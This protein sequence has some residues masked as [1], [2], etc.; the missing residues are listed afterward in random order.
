MRIAAAAASRDTRDPLLT[1]ILAAVEPALA[2][3]TPDLGLLFASSHF[4]DELALAAERIRQATGVR[5]LLGCTAE[6]VIGPDHEHEREPAL[7]LWLASLPGATVRPFHVTQAALEEAGDAASWR[8]LF[9]VEG[10]EQ[11]ALLVLGDPFT[12]NPATLLDGFNRHLPGCPLVGGMASGADGPGQSAL[13]LDGQVH[14]CGAVGV[15]L[16][17]AVRVDTVVSQ[18][19]RPVGQPYVITRAEGNLLYQLG[20]R[21][22]LAV[23]NQVFAEAP[24]TDQEL[25][26]S[27]G[28]YLGRAINEQQGQ[29]R[30]GDF[31]IRNLLG[32]ADEDSGALAVGDLLR[33]GITVQFHVRDAAT[34]A[35]DLRTLL[36]QAAPQPAGVLLFSCNGRGTR[37]FASRD[38]DLL[39]TRQALGPVPVA[40]FFCAGEL[41]PVGGRNFI[42]GHTASLA[43]FRPA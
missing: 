38:Q 10:V 36:G 35:E 40:G 33:V 4:E 23:L 24:A 27:Q 5:T 13:L 34:A 42:H 41:G 26:R 25:M 6:A 37:L 1:R 7:S 12:V 19:C 20:G 43:L 11:P 21:K 18:G 16:A 28:I 31:L 15:A 17:G 3:A 2:G 30:R 8:G 22:A 32:L 39:A 14:R 29:F 9:R